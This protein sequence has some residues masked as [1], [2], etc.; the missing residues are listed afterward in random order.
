MSEPKKKKA[1]VKL[2]FE[3]SDNEEQQE[4]V[5]KV[6][7]SKESRQFK[8]MRQAPVIIEP[9]DHGRSVRDAKVSSIVGGSYSKENLAQLKKAQNFTTYSATISSGDTD[10]NSSG[11]LNR[12]VEDVILSGEA[13][14]EF[15]ALTEQAAERHA[16]AQ[17]A[18][19]TGMTTKN[20][21]VS[22]AAPLSSQISLNLDDDQNDRVYMKPQAAHREFYNNDIKSTSCG[23][24]KTTTTT[25]SSIPGVSVSEDDE[26][27]QEVIRRGTINIK[28]GAALAAQTAGSMTYGSTGF[29]GTSSAAAAAAA[30][31][32]TDFQQVMSSLTT[33]I[34]AVQSTCESTRRRLEQV[35][36]DM[37]IL[38]DEAASLAPI[39]DEGVR[40]LA[41]AQRVRVYFSNVVGMLREK[42]KGINSIVC[43][44]LEIC[45]A[46]TANIRMRRVSAQEDA[47]Y[48]LYEAGQC[49]LSLGDGYKLNE[50]GLLSTCAA[51]AAAAA[52]TAAEI[53]NGN[54]AV[55]KHLTELSSV[56]VLTGWV[57]L[58]PAH[59]RE[60]EK[61]EVSRKQLRRALADK[62]FK[63][64]SAD[65]MHLL[66]NTLDG[67]T[68][69]GFTNNGV[70]NPDHIIMAEKDEDGN[71][72]CST[73][74]YAV[75]EY[76]HP[77]LYKKININS[78]S[79][80]SS[81]SCSEDLSS[82][83]REL[84]SDVDDSV[85]SVTDIIDRISQLKANFRDKYHSA[86]ISTSI[87][88]LLLPFVKLDIAGARPYILGEY[89]Q[90]P[91]ITMGEGEGS[92]LQQSSTKL[93][94][95]TTEEEGGFFPTLDSGGGSRWYS[96]ASDNESYSYEG[97]S[98]ARKR[99]K[100]NG[101]IETGNGGG[102]NYANSSDSPPY[103]NSGSCRS[104]FSIPKR[105]WHA[106]IC[107]F[108]EAAENDSMGGAG[109]DGGG[110]DADDA[111]L[112]PRIVCKGIVPLITDTIK[113]S[114][115]PI[116]RSQCERCVNIVNEVLDYDPEE[117]ETL[118]PLLEAIVHSF[119]T[120][121]ENLCVPCLKLRHANEP[122]T[123]SSTNPGSPARQTVDETL[124]VSFLCKQLWY[125]ESLMQNWVLFS[126]V[127]APQVVGKV[128]ITILRKVIV[129]CA[130]LCNTGIEKVSVQKFDT[131][132][133]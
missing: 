55:L 26:W 92:D 6:K 27:E 24:A 37:S 33:V 42:E 30:A 97:N 66:E 105:S 110:S 59:Q 99:V 76:F 35:R 83:T 113:Y 94:S 25:D 23:V 40:K 87:F 129:P 68:Q 117:A 39:V 69:K 79:S 41:V 29:V 82:R 75:V 106:P 84:L 125:V 31:A 127:L 28:S 111:T 120:E 58:S 85:K 67:M 36:Q 61:R 62:L 89:V 124:A 3:D 11:E 123:T 90:W 7:K 8:K 56:S 86:Y 91:A 57:P 1:S 38:D 5:F 43:D 15:V 128:I 103:T 53:D 65:S 46:M 48:R 115:D 13:A 109:V 20:E 34:D 100:L 49:L 114:L 71:R 54:N 112:L 47:I 44:S 52:A 22:N 102:S 93:R 95:S 78:S 118:S 10:I 17:L 88:D 77:E 101:Q 45:K 4:D 9:N 63:Y 70:G 80:S 18:A 126:A 50:N 116:S 21:V 73:S 122:T 98:S 19:S 51:G 74:I 133:N 72:E 96:N 60:L 108:S 119:A 14:E 16:A 2:S 64:I 12:P 121:I 132:I 81:S 130:C 131:C 107:T 32:A 104:Y